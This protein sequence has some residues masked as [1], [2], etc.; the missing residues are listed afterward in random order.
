[1]TEEKGKQKKILFAEDEVSDEATPVELS[2]TNE[3]TH[4][5]ESFKLKD[6]LVKGIY[7]KGFENPSFIQKRAIP[8]VTSGRDLRAQAQSGTG[9]TGAFVIGA[10]QNI[11]E[12]KQEPQ[13]IVL[14]STREIAQQNATL[15]KEIGVYMNISVCLLAGGSSISNDKKALSRNPQ[16]IVGTPGRVNHM[17][18]EGHLDASTIKIFILDEADEMLKEDFEMQVKDIYVHL[19]VD[20]LQ[21]LFFSATF[22][23]NEL[24]IINNIVS[25]PVVIDL[26]HEEQ[27]LQGIK[28]MFVDVGQLGMQ[29]GSGNRD[30]RGV[31]IKTKVNTLID[32]IKNQ[33]M[34]QMIVFINAKRDALL[35]S[36]LLNA[37]GYPCYLIS[38]D[39]DQTA[40]DETLKNFKEG[41]MRILVSSGLC[42]RGVDVQA[43]SVVV[44]L[45][46]PDHRNDYIHRV[47][48]SGRY[49]RKGVALHIL[50]TPE[51]EAL[52][53]IAEHFH[54]V[55]QPLP[56]GFNFQE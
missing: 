40:R 44:C 4:K 43:L 51:V 55:I 18:D 9:K 48:R 25:D 8:F 38:S 6:A 39:L 11:D 5:W 53:K 7:A 14:V 10:L 2:N 33:T 16:V 17:I 32:I 26:R 52:K 22:D 45:D 49:G 15:F 30:T 42:K 46:V 41:K 34:A 21:A 50:T 24:N 31:E 20:N 3:K 27:T 1:M 12:T 56:A 54:S 37:K 19:N 23:E 47:G 29:M 35:V 28:Q 13:C 36:Q